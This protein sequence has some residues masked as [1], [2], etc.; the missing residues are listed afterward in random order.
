[1]SNNAAM[2]TQTQLHT[3]LAAVNVQ[4]VSRISGVHSKTLYR[5]RQN[6][7]YTTNARTAEAVS[8]ALDK[9]A[10][11]RTVRACKTKVR[12]AFA[13]ASQTRDDFEALELV[14]RQFGLTPEAVAEAVR[15]VAAA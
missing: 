4:E 11:R 1:M 8:T 13:K 12:E 14:A 2:R 6:P 9:I 3:E 7:E 15:K 5:I 10:A